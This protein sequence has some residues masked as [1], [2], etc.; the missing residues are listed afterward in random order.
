M[1]SFAPLAVEEQVGNMKPSN[2][3]KSNQRDLLRSHAELRS[4]MGSAV[5]SYLASQKAIG[6]L[7]RL[8]PNDEGRS[9]LDALRVLT[10]LIRLQQV[11]E[12]FENV[13]VDA[14][15]SW[16]PL[17]EFLWR[18]TARARVKSLEPWEHLQTIGT[19]SELC[20]RLY[21]HS[22]KLVRLLRQSWR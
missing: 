3:A 16:V 18:A 19:L 22:L 2:S 14:I 9:V 21:Q 11:S 20:L 13:A 10:N 5:M 15:A 6:E 4:A 12:T 1:Q 17:N 7:E 8:T